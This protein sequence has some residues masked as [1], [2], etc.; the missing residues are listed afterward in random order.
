VP[1]TEKTFGQTGNADQ[2]QPYF[3]GLPALQLM[4][5]GQNPYVSK[6]TGHA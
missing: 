4:Q 6:Q 2:P 3:I 1:K 5:E